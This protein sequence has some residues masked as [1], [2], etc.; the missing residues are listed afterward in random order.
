MDTERRVYKISEL[1]NLT[2]ELLEG[3]FS[4]IW[5]EG[6]IS[7]FKQ[8]TSGHLYFALKDEVAQIQA[9][10]FK[11]QASYLKFRPEDGLKVIVKGKVSLFVKAGKYQFVVSY[12]EPLGAGPLQVAFEQL[13]R[14]LEGEGLFND[15]Y[16]KELPLLVQKMVIVTSP[17]GAAVHDM[18][19]IMERRFSNVHV[20]I[21]PVHVQGE[22]AAGEIAAAISDINEHFTDIDVI[23]I[24]RGGGSLEDLWP[25]NEEV[26]AR[27]IYKSRLPVISAVGH[28]V[29][30]SIADFVSDLRAPTPSA[31][32]ELVIANKT[33]LE[34]RL[35]SLFARMVSSMEFMFG[36]YRNRYRRARENRVFRRP[37][38]FCE[39]FQQEA[40]YY[41][42]RIST[43]VSHYVRLK[44]DYVRSVIGKLN[45]LSPLNVLSRGYG[46][47][48]KLKNNEVLRDTAMVNVGEKV[49]TRLHKG[50]I[51]CE[52]LEN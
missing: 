34:E 43:S 52:V 13:K 45:A 47:T 1:N 14:K 46:I 37:M 42:E 35:S 44:D 9:V 16:K 4:D 20:L 51:I 29:D 10:M 2:K 30:Y 50:E 32:I 27:A 18:L 23:I 36:D 39:R 41:L 8:H 6:E 25:F 17:T 24:G 5:L 15:E 49:K 48:W 38:E 11:W 21:Y 28:E 31:A 12:I 22:L 3:Q 26:V 7:N 33:E 19:S 40:D